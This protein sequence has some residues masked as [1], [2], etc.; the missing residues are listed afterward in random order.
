VSEARI[1]VNELD[2]LVEGEA[3]VFRFRRGGRALEGFVLR[4]SGTLVAY[5]NVCPHWSVDLDMGTGR[6]WDAAQRRIVCVNHAALFHPLT[7]VC[8]RG[9]CFGDALER[10]EL[11]PEA[12]GAWVTVPEA[13]AEAEADAS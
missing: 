5:A 9:P 11:V 2:T 4:A 8:E 3:R 10:F 7:G 1:Y 12:S 13:E 6:F